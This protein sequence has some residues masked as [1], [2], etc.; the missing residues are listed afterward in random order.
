MEGVVAGRLDYCDGLLEWKKGEAR[1]LSGPRNCVQKRRWDK[2]SSNKN[3][4]RPPVSKG[5][6]CLYVKKGADGIGEMKSKE[7]RDDD[8]YC[9][10]ATCAKGQQIKRPGVNLGNLDPK[11]Q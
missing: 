4:K 6:Q 8:H 7:C 1:R 9:F 11:F 5:L 3:I 2:L 10:E